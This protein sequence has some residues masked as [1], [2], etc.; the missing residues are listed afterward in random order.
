MLLKGDTVGDE[1]DTSTVRVIQSTAEQM[2][3]PN[4]G[5]TGANASAGQKCLL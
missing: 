2:Q 5:K 1:C 3:L 4:E